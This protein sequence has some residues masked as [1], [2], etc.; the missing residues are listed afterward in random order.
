MSA[1]LF[2]S[3]LSCLSESHLFHNRANLR[4]DLYVKKGKKKEA[5][6]QLKLLLFLTCYNILCFGDILHALF[7]LMGVLVFAICLLKSEI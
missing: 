7:M 5:F 3:F 4:G 1:T 2:Y 6:F